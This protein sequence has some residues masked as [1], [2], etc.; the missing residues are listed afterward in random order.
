M[1]DLVEDI[2]SKQICKKSYN[3]IKCSVLLTVNG[4]FQQN[5]VNTQV[6]NNKIYPPNK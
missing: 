1:S 4:N 6:I 2:Q 5:N 3:L